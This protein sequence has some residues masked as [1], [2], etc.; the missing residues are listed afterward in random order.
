MLCRYA[1]PASETDLRSQPSQL[2]PHLDTYG[3]ATSVSA[4]ACGLLACTMVA[5][6]VR[7][8]WCRPK[9]VELV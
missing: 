9:E 4:M 2:P 1:A 6:G 8:W 3:A 5:V 7:R